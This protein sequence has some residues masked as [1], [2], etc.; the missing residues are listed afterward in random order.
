MNEFKSENGIYILSR[1]FIAS[2]V[3]CTITWGS[4]VY[5]LPPPPDSEK[6]LLMKHKRRGKYVKEG[7]KVRYWLKN[8]RK[9]RKGFVSNI[10]DSS[11]W[12]GKDQVMIN[13]IRY[14]KKGLKMDL[15]SEWKPQV[16]EYGE[17]AEWI[18][19]YE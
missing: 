11:M 14:L 13:D 10:T 15:V 16:I 1:V 8:E 9:S 3:F 5:D 4:C 18:E 7:N 2:L 6:I 19:N 17:M 12:I